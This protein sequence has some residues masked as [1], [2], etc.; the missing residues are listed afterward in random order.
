MM[1]TQIQ[2]EKTQ[3]SIPPIMPIAQSGGMVIRGEIKVWITDNKTGKKRLHFHDKNSIQANYAKAIVDELD[4]GVSFA[5]DNMFDGNHDLSGTEDGED[6]IAIKD[7]GGSWY[8]MDMETPSV[9]GGFITFIGKF[10][11]VHI[12]VANGTDVKLGHNWI[13]TGD[14]FGAGGAELYAT[15]SSWNSTEVQVAETLTI[16]W[17]IKHSKS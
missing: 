2:N 14:D 11:G 9:S 16:E 3:K 17:I 6:G 7:D 10:T 4:G 15:A 13:D 5:L 8:E 12:T 1:K